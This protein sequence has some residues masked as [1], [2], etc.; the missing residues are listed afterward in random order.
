MKNLGKSQRSKA[1]LER[2]DLEI[3]DMLIAVQAAWISLSSISDLD[4]DDLSED[5][6]SDVLASEDQKKY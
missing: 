5:E 3:L 1:Y 4:S 2:D 6:S